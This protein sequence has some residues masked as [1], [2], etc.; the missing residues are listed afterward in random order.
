MICRTIVMVLSGIVIPL[1]FNQIF[2]NL[3]IEDFQLLAFPENAHQCLVTAV[4]PHTR[5]SIQR[6]LYIVN[7]LVAIFIYLLYIS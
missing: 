5:Q 4:V 1:E 2:D 3:A 6:V 7:F